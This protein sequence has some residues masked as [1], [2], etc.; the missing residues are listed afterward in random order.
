MNYKE[1]ANNETLERVAKIIAKERG[2]RYDD[3]LVADVGMSIFNR[4]ATIEK[5]RSIEAA[6]NI[7]KLGIKQIKESENREVRWA[8]EGRYDECPRWFYADGFSQKID[9]ERE[10]S[11]FWETCKENSTLANSDHLAVGSK[12]NWS[13][14]IAKMERECWTIDKVEWLVTMMLGKDPR[15]AKT[16]RTARRYKQLIKEIFNVTAKSSKHCNKLVMCKFDRAGAVVLDPNHE[17]NSKSG[18]LAARDMDWFYTQCKKAQY[19]REF[20]NR[21]RDPRCGAAGWH[22]NLLRRWNEALSRL[23]IEERQFIIAYCEYEVKI[24]SIEQLQL[25]ERVLHEIDNDEFL[26]SEKT[27]LCEEDFDD[28]SAIGRDYDDSFADVD[29][30]ALVS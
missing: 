4:R 3:A 13:Y 29:F 26:K 25:L 30:E 11:S 14:K 28:E 23:S 12:S 1:L 5:S 21:A 18:E 17:W 22:F 15:K 2:V 10:S 19:W 20:F 7:I 9:G 8:R 24:T 27:P 6:I 16:E